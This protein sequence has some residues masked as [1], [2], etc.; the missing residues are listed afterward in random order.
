ML[1]AVISPL[2]AAGVGYGSQNTF[3]CGRV[4]SGKPTPADVVAEL[5]LL[6]FPFIQ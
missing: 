6:D 3:I 5:Q 4:D 1:C 2:V